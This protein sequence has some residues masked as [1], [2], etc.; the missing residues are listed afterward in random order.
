M[1]ILTG[2]EKGPKRDAVL[3]NAGTSVFIAGKANSIQEGID[4][5]KES[6]DSGNAMKK[7]EAL[8]EFTNKN[9]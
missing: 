7:L 5:A 3:L 6:I 8:K 9:A 2:K 1:D 4:I